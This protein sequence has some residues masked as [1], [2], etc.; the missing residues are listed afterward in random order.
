MSKHDKYTAPRTLT[1]PQ[2][3]VMSIEEE[4]H[5]PSAEDRLHGVENW[6]QGNS[7]MVNYALIGILA[8]L[9][10]VFGYKYYIGGQ[11]KK[12]NDAIFRAQT[13]YS[14]DSIN[15]ALNGDG[16]NLGFKKIADKYSGTPAGNLANYY[17]GIC[18]LKTGDFA[19]AEKYLKSF[20]GKGTLV[21][22]VAKGALGDALMEQGKTDDAIKQY[23]DAS[24]DNDNLLVSPLYLERA[25]LAY[26]LKNNTTEAIATYKKLKEKFPQSQQARNMDKNLARLGVY[27]VE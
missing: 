14:I 13:Y 5:I 2:A 20:D 22:N 17:A 1:N 16:N 26:E 25:G 10:G 24:S 12:A 7:K 15:W 11:S 23:L 3:P 21:T 4:L 9:V 18:C 27:S 6:Y 19:N 8:I